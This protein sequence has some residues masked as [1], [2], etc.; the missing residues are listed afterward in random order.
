MEYNMTN[1]FLESHAQNVMDKFFADPS[2]K[3]QN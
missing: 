3:N 1:I 2:L